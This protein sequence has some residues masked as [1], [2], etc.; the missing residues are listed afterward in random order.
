M[1]FRTSRHSGHLSPNWGTEIC[2]WYWL[3]HYLAYDFRFLPEDILCNYQYTW[4]FFT[5][6]KILKKKTKKTRKFKSG[7]EKKTVALEWRID[8]NCIST[9]PS[10]STWLNELAVVKIYYD[11]FGSRSRASS[12]HLRKIVFIAFRLHHSTSHSTCQCRRCRN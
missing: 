10:V 2:F 5:F 8:W 7:I 4:T 11:K 12:R 9:V 1:F 6:Q 3:E